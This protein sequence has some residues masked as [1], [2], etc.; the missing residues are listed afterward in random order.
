M[1]LAAV[2]KVLLK[3]LLVV[4]G[5]ACQLV[6]PLAVCNLSRQQCCWNC[7]AWWWCSRLCSGYSTKVNEAVQ[8]QGQ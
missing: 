7:M 1:Q 3:L 8:L 6:G 2:V 5:T 4:K